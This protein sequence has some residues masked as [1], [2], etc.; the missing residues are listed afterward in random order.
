MERT[1]TSSSVLNV[2]QQLTR[3]VQVVTPH[4]TAQENARNFTGNFTNLN[5]VLTRLIPS[6]KCHTY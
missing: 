1:G 5:V 2:V 3:D 6:D 4:S